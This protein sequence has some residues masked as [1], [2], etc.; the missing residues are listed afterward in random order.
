MEIIGANNQNRER[1]YFLSR[2]LVKQDYTMLYRASAEVT[3]WS[4]S[5]R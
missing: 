4:I 1:K 5:L 3:I 2:Q